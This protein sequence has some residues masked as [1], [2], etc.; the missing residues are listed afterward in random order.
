MHD[1]ERTFIMTKFWDCIFFPIPL[2]TLVNRYTFQIS[3][4]T[5][6]LSLSIDYNRID[7]YSRDVLVYDN[8]RSRCFLLG[9]HRIDCYVL[10]TY[11]ILYLIFMPFYFQLTCFCILCVH[12]IRFLDGIEDPYKNETVIQRR[13]IL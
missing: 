13:L 1:G 11:C 10:C 4:L 6:L 3:L 2:N 7:C 9:I 5:V 12:F 8:N